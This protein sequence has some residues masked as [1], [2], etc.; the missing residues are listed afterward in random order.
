LAISP[1]NSRST[2]RLWDGAPG[3]R[4]GDRPVSSFIHSAGLP[5]NTS[6]IEVLRRPVEST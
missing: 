5:I 6:I 4:I 2:S 1:Q 3:D